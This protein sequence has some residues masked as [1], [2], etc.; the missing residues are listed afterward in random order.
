MSHETSHVDLVNEL[1]QQRAKGGGEHEFV[2]LARKLDVAV[3]LKLVNYD[4]LQ[5]LPPQSTAAHS[6]ENEVIYVLE[7]IAVHEDSDSLFISLMEWIARLL[8]ESPLIPP[9]QRIW[10][11]AS[12]AN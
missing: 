6:W 2:H 9:A 1:W 11:G 7:W 3:H 12:T 8:D 10:N 4:Y 5:Q